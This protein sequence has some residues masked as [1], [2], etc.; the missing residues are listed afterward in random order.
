[1]SWYLN[2]GAAELDC[3]AAVV[4]ELKAEALHGLATDDTQLVIPAAVGGGEDDLGA[5]HVFL[6][7][8]AIRDDRLK[9]TTVR[10]RDGHDN[11]CSHLESLNYFA[12]LGIA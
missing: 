12:R 5:P 6:S 10:G 7:R 1:M 8:T 4:L 9:L 2:R 3:S 11:S